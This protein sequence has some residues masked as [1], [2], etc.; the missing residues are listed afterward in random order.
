MKGIISTKTDVFSYGVLM[1]EIISGKKN[2]CRYR[3]DYPLNLIEFVSN[4]I[5]VFSVQSL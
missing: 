1:L 5:Q 2:N 3:S 4:K